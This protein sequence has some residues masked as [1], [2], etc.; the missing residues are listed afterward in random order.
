MDCA[1]CNV[2]RRGDLERGGWGG[3]ISWHDFDIQNS[4]KDS[5]SKGSKKGETRKLEMEGKEKFWRLAVY[6]LAISDKLPKRDQGN[7]GQKCLGK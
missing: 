1:G 3:E 6:I 4:K 2:V 5:N 7:D